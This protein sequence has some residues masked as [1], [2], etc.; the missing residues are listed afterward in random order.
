MLAKLAHAQAIAGRRSMNLISK[1]L[2]TWTLCKCLK[3]PLTYSGWTITY[4]S[5]G[6]E[7]RQ[8]L[9]IRQAEFHEA[10]G[11]DDAVEYIPADLEVVVWVH[12]DEFENHLSCKDAC[13]DLEMKCD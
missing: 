13:E 8:P 9:Y 7:H 3:R 4:K 10:H 2:V 12:G 11:H 1:K 6:P 5:E